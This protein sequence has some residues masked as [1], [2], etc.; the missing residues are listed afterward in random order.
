MFWY[1]EYVC[2]CVC[3]GICI[4]KCGCIYVYLYI[5]SIFKW[6]IIGYYT[7]E[8]T[9]PKHI[10]TSAQMTT[11]LDEP[12]STWNCSRK[13]KCMCYQTSTDINTRS[14][15]LTRDEYIRQH[16]HCISS[17]LLVCKV[18]GVT[19]KPEYKFYKKTTQ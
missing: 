7:V 17:W 2:D 14:T 11:I 12:Q 4:C 5:D 6:I 3:M 16:I 13:W 15:S 1:F 8:C 18:A 10:R 19:N 9:I